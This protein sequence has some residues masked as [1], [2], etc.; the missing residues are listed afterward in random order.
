MPPRP[1]KAATPSL[2]RCYAWRGTNAHAR[3]RLLDR[4]AGAASALPTGVDARGRHGRWTI[5]GRSEPDYQH[6]NRPGQGD[7]EASTAKT[8]PVRCRESFVDHRLRLQPGWETGQF[9]GL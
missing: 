5:R 8:S 9:G 4:C 1:Y 7:D 3:A 6:G 2:P